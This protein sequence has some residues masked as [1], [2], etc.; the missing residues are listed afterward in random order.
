MNKKITIV[1]AREF[2]NKILPAIRDFALEARVC[3]PVSLMALKL[4]CRDTD[5]VIIDRD[6]F[7]T[8]SGLRDEYS[9]F[10]KHLRTEFIVC[11]SGKN[12]ADIRKIILSGA[13]D[14]ILKPASI[15][16]VKLRVDAVFNR[17]P[18]LA[19]LGGG[20]GLFNLL[21]GLKELKNL[22]VTSL[23]STSD[24]GNSSGK[25][26]AIFGVLPP[27][28]IRRSLVALST[29]PQLMNDVMQYRFQTGAGL[30]GHSFGNL[31]LTALSE[32]KGGMCE[33]VRGLGDLLNINGF[34]FPATATNTNLCAEFEDGTI[35]RGESKID[36][37]EKRK[38]TLKIVRCWHDPACA[39]DMNAYA[40]I[41][42]ADFVTIGP[43]DLFTSVITDLLIQDIRKALLETKAKKIYLCNVMT[44]PGETS[45]FTAADHVREI[46]NYLKKD[47]LD[48]V[49]IPDMSGV[50]CAALQ[51]YARKHQRPVSFGGAKELRRLTKAKVILADVVHQTELV[52]H[53]SQKIARAI[54]SIINT[55]QKRRK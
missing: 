53:D 51:Q 11:S 46:L 26:K 50:S 1:G 49:I 36:L 41:L 15:R 21:M 23:V 7:K 33:A 16:E 4:G 47:V 20:T 6:Y 37:C 10:L 8:I 9:R 31:F 40:A 24:D 14:V 22:L 34:V 28:D 54:E 30:N 55:K 43:G 12:K 35:V 18:K 29:A 3:T 13:A 17:K 27:G 45:G 48:Y 32:I 25:L 44:K 39:A 19:C 42:N 5:L 2:G 38:E 52:R